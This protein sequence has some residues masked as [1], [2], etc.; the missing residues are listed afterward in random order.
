MNKVARGTGLRYLWMVFLMTVGWWLY[1]AIQKGW[2][3]IG[4]VF[5]D[6]IYQPSVVAA[7]AVVGYDLFQNTFWKTSGRRRVIRGLACKGS[8]AAGDTQVDI[9]VGETTYSQLFN[10][11]TGFPNMDD[12]F[13]AGNI[14]VPPGS[15]ISAIV[16]DAPATNPINMLI[17]LVG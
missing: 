13:P 3:A 12:V 1:L 6:P 11:S 14:P 5:G 15:P 4:G 8:A 2:N 10:T 17:D 9:L 16:R 7:T